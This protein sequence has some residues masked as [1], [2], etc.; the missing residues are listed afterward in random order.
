MRYRR[1]AASVQAQ[2][3]GHDYAAGGP[4]FSCSLTLVLLPD[5]RASGLNLAAGSDSLVVSGGGIR[6]DGLA[7]EPAVEPS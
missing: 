5:P 3:E 7:R 1:I 6:A 2:V 4:R